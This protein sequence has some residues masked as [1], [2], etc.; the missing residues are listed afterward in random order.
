MPLLVVGTLAFDSV[1]TPHGE[2]DEILGGS[3]SYAATAAAYFGPVQMVGI[4]GEDFAEAH[5]TDFGQRG[6]D[7]TGVARAAGRTFRWRGVYELNMNIRHTLET[8]LNVLAEF[9]PRLPPTYRSTPFAVL[10]NFDP[11]LQ[12]EVLE[13]LTAP[14]C[15]ACDTMNFWIAGDRAALLRTL[16]RVDLLLVNDSEARELAGVDDL[17]RAATE[18]RALGPRV[19]VIKLGEQGAKLYDDDGILV[20]PAFPVARVLDPTG[21]G[22]SFAGGMMG[23]LAAQPRLDAAALRDAMVLGTVMASFSVEDFST[24]GL[25]HLTRAAIDERLDRYCALHGFSRPAPG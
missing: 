14:R 6:I 25:R 3:A 9:R 4:I 10:G 23:Y 13:Q 15:V 17:D 11:T 12:L 19:V 24:E 7:T 21:A 22:D 1:K 16:R 20:T 5:L 8:Q 18:V 2:R